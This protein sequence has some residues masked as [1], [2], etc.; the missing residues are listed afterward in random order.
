ME[1]A[2][3]FANL[4]IVRLRSSLN[5]VSLNLED[6]GNDEA[7]CL[8]Y[9]GLRCKVFNCLFRYFQPYFQNE[10]KTALSNAQQFVVTLIKL[11]LNL[12]YKDLAYRFGVSPQ[13]VSR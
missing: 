13:T 2:L 11:R 5:N 12:K 3:E 4:S 6:L 9:T 8:F 10:H 7:K 1:K